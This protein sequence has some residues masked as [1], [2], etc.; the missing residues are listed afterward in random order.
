MRVTVCD[1]GGQ[2]LEALSRRNL[3]GEAMRRCT[4]TTISGS[5]LTLLTLSFQIIFTE[6]KRANYLTFTEIIEY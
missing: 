6:E 1:G 2:V 4:R 5:R 3:S